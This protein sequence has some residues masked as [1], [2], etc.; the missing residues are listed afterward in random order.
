MVTVDLDW[1]DN[2]YTYAFL[3]GSDT[4]TV[5]VLGRTFKVPINT[6]DGSHSF[7]FDWQPTMNTTVSATA[8]FRYAPMCSDNVSP[9]SFGPCTFDLALRKTIVTP[10]SP[11]YK[12]G[13]VLQYR[14][15]VFNQGTIP[16]ANINIID[17]KPVGLE[18]V[19]AQNPDWFLNPQNNAEAFIPGPILPG[20]SVFKDI[21]Y[22]ILMHT[23]S[24]DAWTNFAEITY[25]ED[26]AGNNRSNYDVDSSPDK[27]PSNDAGGQPGTA[28]DNRLDGN[29]TDDS[30]DHDGARFSIFDL[31][32]IK[33]I[34]TPPPYTFGQDVQFDITVINQGNETANTI[35][36]VDNIPSG[37]S[38]RPVNSPAWSHSS[39]VATRTIVNP[40]LPGTSTTIP[41]I[42]RIESAASNQYVNIA[43]ISAATNSAGM[44]ATDFD[45]IFDSDPANDPGGMPDTPSDNAQ[46]G[47]GTGTG[48]PEAGD[49][50]NMDVARVAIPVISLQKS[51]VSIAPASSGNVANNDV[52]FSLTL[53]N[54]GNETLTMLTL[55]DNFIAQ[56]GGSFIRIVNMPSIF[57]STAT[58]NPVLN[59]AFNGGVNHQIFNGMTGVL[60]PTQSIQVRLTLELMD[61]DPVNPLVNEAITTGKD[62]F[63]S[64]V[65][66]TAQANVSLPTC[67]LKVNCPVPNQ[68]NFSCLSQVPAPATTVAAFNSQFG[69]NAIERFCSTP[70]ITASDIVTGTGCAA[71]PRVIMRRYIITDSGITPI[72]IQRD[73]C[74]VIYT[75][76]DSIKPV[77]MTP[78][79][80]II[81]ECGASG[82]TAAINTWLTQNGKSVVMDNCGGS[83]TIMNS[84]EEVNNTCGGTTN[85]KYRFT[86]TDACG[87]IQVAYGNVI[88][89]DRTA[90]SLTLPTTAKTVSCSPTT[91]ANTALANW[92][93][94]ASSSDACEGTI[95]VSHAL[96]TTQRVCTATNGTNV[97]N[98]YNFSATDSCGNFRTARDTFTIVDN[99]PPT[100]T[101]PTNLTVGCGQD[102]GAAVV[103][104][105]DNY[106]VSEACQTYSVTNNFNGQI[107][108]LCGGMQTVTWTVT[109]GCGATGST[110]AMI[111]VTNDNARPTWIN[112]PSDMTVNV[113]VD[114]C[115]A[116]VIFSRPIASDCNGP[117][118]YAQ[119]A[120]PISGS[121]FPLGSTL[122]R[123]TARDRCGNMDTCSFNIVVTDS[124][125]P[126]VR[127]PQ[128]IT[129]CNDPGTCTWASTV[130]TNPIGVDNCTGST[131]SYTISGVTSGSGNDSVPL[132]TSF[133]LGIS[134]I[135]YIITAP[136]G[137][138][139]T[140]RFTILVRDCQTPVITCPTAQPLF[141][142]GNATL[143]ADISSWLNT[144]SISDNCAPTPS[145]TVNRISTVDQCGNTERRL[146]QI[147]ATD[148]ANNQSSCFV[149]AV[150]TDT[151]R[152]VIVTPAS[153][154]TVQ[155]NGVGNI[156]SLMAWLTNHG[157]AVATDAGCGNE[158]RWSHNFNGL[159]DLCS[160][161][162]SA[163]VTFTVTDDCGNSRQTTATFTIEDTTPPTITVP[164]NLTLSCGNTNN[165]SIISGWL[166]SYVALDMCGSVTVTNDFTT[167]P[168]TCVAPNN[169]RVVTF[170][171]TDACG[172]TAQGMATVTMVDILKP[173]VM[174]PPSD[175]IVQCGQDNVSTISNWINTRGGAMIADE[176]APGL[177][178]TFTGAT[179]IRTCGSTA[180]TLYTL[181]ATDSCG[182]TVTTF[183]SLITIDTS[184]PIIT[185]P[186]VV[187]SVLCDPNTSAQQA[188]DTWLNNASASDLCQGNVNVVTSLI[189]T[190]RICRT[191]NQTD[192]LHI[193]LFTATDGC[194][195]ISTGRDTFRIYDNV[196]PN[197][198]A[199]ADLTI[200]CGQEIGAA[201]IP[202]LNGYTVTEACQT[203]T[204]TNNYDGQIPNLCGGSQA[205]MWT[206]T[207]GCGATNT[208]SANIVVA[209]NNNKPTFVNCPPNLTVNVDADLCSSNVIYSTPVAND[210]NGSVNVQRITGLASGSRFPL[211][212]TMIEFEAINACGVRDT[213]RF[214]ITV[215]DSIAP[216]IQCPGNDVVV[217]A[218]SS[219]V[220]L[221]TTAIN[222]SGIENCPGAN[223][224]YLITGQ[225]SGTGTGSVPLSTTF[226]LGTSTIRYI[227]IAA[228]GQRDTCQ[229]NVIVNDCTP[230]AIK[231]P[232]NL[233]LQCD[234]SGNDAAI[235]TWRN[236]VT[237]SDNCTV[238]I[239]FT[240]TL[241]S[242]VDQCGNSERRLY[243]FVA[244]D[245]ADNIASCFSEVIVR[246]TIKPAITTQASNLLVECDGQGNTAQL[247]N[248]L[249]TNGGAVGTD[250]CGNVRWTNNFG[251][252]S[253]LCGNSGA[254]TVRFTALDDCENDSTTTATFTIRDTS[255]PVLICPENITI[256]CGNTLNSAVISN[257]L[258][259]ATAQDICSG[260]V[261][262]T[263][264]YPGT[265]VAGCGNT[266]VH[267]VSF[268]ARDAC[269]SVTT[270]MRTITIIDT[271]RPIITSPPRDTV[272]QCDGT[273]NL[274]QLNTWLRHQAG[275]LARDTCSVLSS[276]TWTTPVLIH[277][278]NNC[279]G[280]RVYTYRFVSADACGNE[281]LPSFAT[282][283]ILDDTIPMISVPAK[284]SIVQCDGAGNN[285]QL[286]GWLSAHGGAIASDICSGPVTWS[287]N[288][289]RLTQNCGRTG[290]QHYRFTVMDACGKTNYTEAN[291]II[292]DTTRPVIVNPAVNFQ[293]QCDGSNNASQ[294]LNWLNNNGFASALD[295]CNGVTW[296]ND[297]GTISSPCGTTGA[298]NVT[299]TATDICG[300]RNTTTAIFT[301]R[302]TIA[303]RWVIA[304]QN[305]RLT[306]DGTSNPNEG[307][308]SWLNTVG[309]GLATDSCSLV[310]YSN[311]FT[312]LSN[313]CSAN[314][315][316][317]TVTFYGRD[318]CGNVDSLR[319]T[320]VVEDI[321]PPSIQ[322]PAKDT[323]VNCNGSGNISQLNIWLQN[324]GGAIASDRCSGV[325]TW[326]YRRIDTILNCG[327]T[328]EIRYAFTATDSCNNTSV[329]TIAKFII[330]DTMPPMVIQLPRDTV[331]QCNGSGNTGVLATWLGDFGGFRVSDVCSGPVT[332]SRTLIN[333]TDLC[334]L[335][336]NGRYKFTATDRCGNSISA[337]AE[338]AI[339]D[340]IAPLITPGADSNIGDCAS[341]GAGNYP[342][343]DFWLTNHAGAKAAD[344]CGGVTWSNNYHPSN[345]VTQCGNARFVFV[346]FYATD[347]CGNVDSVRYRFGVGDVSPPV[348]T[349][350]PRP[351]IIVDAPEGWCSA[352]ANFSPMTATDNCSVVTVRQIDNTG[353]KSGSLFPVG[354]TILYF[355]AKDGCG[356]ADTCSLK[357]IVNDFHVPPVMTC[358]PS[359]TVNNDP[360]RCGAIVNGLKPTKVEDNCS[361]NV[362]VSYTIRDKDN[363]IISCGFNDA[364]GFMFPVGNNIVSY[365]AKDQPTL[366][367]TEVINDGVRNGVEITNFGPAAVN[368]ACL[369]VERL[370]TTPEIYTVEDTVLRVGGVYTHLF[371]NIPANSPSGYMIRFMDNMIDGVATNGYS[372]TAF[373]WT[374][375]L[376][377]GTAYRH[378]VCDTD[379]SQDFRTID[380]CNPHSF[381]LFNPGLPV[382]PDNGDT[383]SLQ[384]RPPSIAVCNVNVNVRDAEFPYC[385][386][387]DTITYSAPGL[388]ANITS[389]LCTA[390]AV[391]VPVSPNNI[392]TDIN[393]INLEGT[394]PNVGDLVFRLVSPAGKEVTLMSGVCPSA[395]N[396]DINF[397]DEASTSIS[398][399]ACTTPVG[400]NNTFR[401]SQL[402]RQ[403]FGERSDGT[404]LL[405]VFTT[406]TH[407]G[408]LTNWQLQIVRSATYT[409][410]DT[411]LS[412][413]TGRCGANFRWQ[414]P[415]LA[416][417]CGMGTIRVDYTTSDGINVPGS[418]LLAGLGGQVTS[419]YFEVGTT[420]ITY[421]LTDQA[422]NV[423]RCSFE[424]TVQ[425]SERPEINPSSCQNLT[426]AL[427]PTQCE[428]SIPYPVLTANDNCGITRFVYSP[429]AGTRFKEGTHSVMLIVY[430]KAG[431]AD[432]CNFTVTVLPFVPS[433]NSMTCHSNINV[434]LDGNCQSV[435]GPEILLTGTSY[436]CLADYCVT[437][438]DASGKVIGS[439][440]NLTNIL[441]KDHI[442]KII[443]AKVCQDC[444]GNG[445]CCWATIKVEAK[446]IPV[447]ECPKNI[448]I[449]CNESDDPLFTG[450]PILKSCEPNIQISFVDDYDENDYC[451]NP[452]AVIDRI[453]TIRD[454][455]NNEVTCNQ[456][457][458]VLPF[459]LD[460]IRFPVDYVLDDSYDC[461]DVAKN[462]DLISVD[463]TGYPTISGKDVFGDHLCEFNIG[464]WD[465]KLIDA[466]C[467]SSFEILRHWIIRDECRPVEL[468]KNPLRHIQFIKVNDKKPPVFKRC[469]DD[470]TISTSDKNCTGEF[471]LPALSGLI[472]DG[473][474]SIRSISVTV[475]GGTVV[476]TGTG[477][478]KNYA[479]TNL[480][481][482]EHTVKI[483]AMDQCRNSALCIFK[484]TVLDKTPPLAICNG[485][486]RVSLS[487]DGK[488]RLVPSVLDRGSY[489][490][491]TSIGYQIYRRN[492][493]CAG[494]KDTLP[495]QHID[496]CCDD[497][498]LSPV[499]VVLRVWDDAD[500]DG[501]F[502]SPGDNY[503][504]CMSSVIV[505]YKLAP[506]FK[507]PDPVTLT[508][509]RDYK[510]LGLTGQPKVSQACN[511]A[512]LKFEDDIRALN[513]CGIGHVTRRWYEADRPQNSCQQQIIMT[514]IS[515]IDET[516]I[517]WP[518]D[519]TLF[520]TQTDYNSVPFIP[521]R[522]CHQ[523]GVT[524]KVDTIG[525]TQ[526]GCYKVLKHWTV[527]DWCQRE[528][529]PNKGKWTHTQT[530][531][532]TDNKAPVIQACQNVEITHSGC[533]LDTLDIVASAVDSGCV[534]NH[535][536]TWNVE[537][538]INDD[539]TID[540]TVTL[541][542][543]QVKYKLINANIGRLMVKWTVRDACNN[544][545]TCNQLIN[546]VSK[547]APLTYCKN[548][549]ISLS[550]TQDGIVLKAKDFNNGSTDACGKANFLNFSFSNVIADSVKRFN[551]SDIPNGVS[552]LIPITLWVSDKEGNKSQCAANL[553]V[554]DN[555]NQCPDLS[556]VTNSISGRVHTESGNGME[557][558]KLYSSMERSEL[559]HTVTYTDQSGKF[560][561]LNNHEG[562]VYK[563]QPEY[564]K[565]WLNGV[566]TLDLILIQRHILGL[567]QIKNPYLLLA[568]DVNNDSK[569]TSADLVVLRKLILGIQETV[570][571]QSSWIFV[572]KNF[573]FT[574]INNPWLF[575]NHL[576]IEQSKQDVVNADFIALKTGDINSSASANSNNFITEARSQLPFILYYDIQPL[577]VGGQ[578]LIRFYSSDIQYLKGLQLGFDVGDKGKLN[579][580]DGSMIVDDSEYHITGNKV[581][582]SLS[583]IKIND[584]S[585]K[586]LFG[587]I[588]DDANRIELLSN[589]WKNEAYL[590]DDLHI[591]PIKLQKTLLPNDENAFIV[592]QN[593]PNP[594]KDQTVIGFNI[595]SDDKVDLEIRDVNG[596]IVYQ[597]STYF[598]KGY[599]EWILKKSSLPSGVFSYT[600]KYKNESK[601]NKMIII[602]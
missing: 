420:V 89:L 597:N 581:R 40:L 15:E 218:N 149:E 374:G 511:L 159:S 273:G 13:D 501:V 187:D 445:N 388:P 541:H 105:L 249:N 400:Q 102:I 447:V 183:A 243:Y 371:T 440:A 36:V 14:I 389:G 37:Y 525:S 321:T 49:E 351:P 242:T 86:A 302:D 368:I 198:V 593:I 280:T 551:C 502:G 535:N 283:S 85:T 52:T 352:F 101:A 335:T 383:T 104:W 255:R 322:S 530:I 443:T 563:I 361:N 11:A 565:N 33:T 125:K 194:G 235:L 564:D 344:V 385:S 72:G 601:S 314:T 547:K 516:S 259:T 185:L 288:L 354:T 333:E 69:V 145:R 367:I 482:G 480:T 82:N 380:G 424:V 127:C 549:A 173:V 95:R 117:V 580:I 572:P 29:G 237:G 390:S 67:F 58:T 150:I 449:N 35:T 97:L 509:D 257:W 203:Y 392:I 473:C 26:N 83:V 171:A 568:A 434:S 432:T 533:S 468:N 118:T 452:R 365:T 596:K 381:G 164:S 318:A 384:S 500:K 300:N 217:C 536:L 319:A 496:L 600:L 182:N 202:W 499:M 460:S 4:I 236:S 462:P 438:M 60:A 338:F 137:Q 477:V 483:R 538:D 510:N 315:G 270:C 22:R 518:L 461:D 316:N 377:A 573:R 244:R 465:E 94:S 76:V 416:D 296:T 399:V 68:G 561:F 41:I 540:R 503:A 213:C 514:P 128:N 362:T 348:F 148:A 253:D 121:V 345:W 495:S 190:Q 234:D 93:N 168:N 508:C 116:N 209:L 413:E 355:E 195:I 212:T 251:T 179:P 369:S 181:T 341:T 247:L 427:N 557:D 34:V 107:P 330:R 435:I 405:E 122:V 458:V 436:G 360:L 320:V 163:V 292:Q 429:P 219:C 189:N 599:N 299:F 294:I 372:P 114:L 494:S 91:A 196:R 197:I 238:N 64:I 582:L 513:S 415:R 140:C 546:V 419:Q 379:N 395:A 489:D 132:N 151:I 403:F 486:L 456:K 504:E 241:I 139:D 303:P 517:K 560:S 425:D 350:C 298:V 223:I 524:V 167:L 120:G 248:W 412:N 261:T 263:N 529:D 487:S 23:G 75:V 170:T 155:C 123:F 282:F 143:E 271:Q 590:F 18:F 186:T 526:D 422:G 373:S 88:L 153:N 80:D 162:G 31:A 470:V 233:T 592:F 272:T 589:M 227:V 7:T 208:A 160:S 522:L 475:N 3:N 172:R 284:D 446:N 147:T 177:T 92:L 245:T 224:E 577:E 569:V 71:S 337:E 309:G 467:K 32:L 554:Q 210:C 323:I 281:S 454:I 325:R 585:G 375:T 115:S 328:R 166:E 602:E 230:P 520:C 100:I 542:G 490:N 2:V 534:L 269:D 409:Q 228:N 567:D 595:Y 537:I 220:W 48:S 188:L 39:G 130:A 254:V 43:E 539:G 215:Q 523:L 548:L 311:N 329:E 358:P 204:I 408:Q 110:S 66:D 493:S 453:W 552:V 124:Q 98:V 134:T 225:T 55:S 378:R 57:S 544:A 291:F 297:Y 12:Y 340:T 301:I 239:Q 53:Q 25:A 206:V 497:I 65:R 498:A 250:R 24:T 598:N 579:F 578:S 158:I 146:Y 221:S 588:A 491:C 51:V 144:A 178:Y 423:S 174:R 265:F 268:T 6:V 442:G 310:T 357:V 96:V 156:D 398:A 586:P 214:S 426:A 466:N 205:V 414:H 176:C 17:Y 1:E 138:R 591:A 543:N 382:M 262:L 441:N 515:S 528:L 587:F 339:I 550:N 119:I 267:T 583:N 77:F 289:V 553:S 129:V 28:N 81:L 278:L 38:Y 558:V 54:P 108:N 428:I 131:I 353:Y 46:N 285:A 401:P 317:A 574:D 410:E 406:G 532:F 78:P 387:S 324:N 566:S 411:V 73:T 331:V 222:P 307:I 492:T 469:F 286:S 256:E 59:T 246:D 308:T 519:T 332:Y 484:I 8:S 376:S 431:N 474:G 507:C 304:P 347:I 450:A 506:E 437:L 313:G 161:T 19:L 260:T 439:S 527:L 287:Y 455:D 16:A 199:P 111:I 9:G 472:E 364:S 576:M 448:T 396:F 594:W 570:P 479:F 463:S 476:S 10:T 47:N 106:S 391:S 5:D 312:R 481:V 157:G 112:C 556:G 306:C 226:N 216:R 193:Y 45:G 87:N 152:P 471:K 275:A 531:K 184:A 84:I 562:Q 555:A 180:N 74:T 142:C 444:S 211:G 295:A 327:L 485:N 113:D 61:V 334:G 154:R 70:T 133:G 44:S 571:N 418:G 402:L 575:P 136:N 30:D 366:L 512:Q 192:I 258:A 326:N 430:D 264:N 56:F 21:Y 200:S 349:N 545:S 240:S 505:D 417:N 79:C 109:D 207:D 394:Y 464:Y 451:G 342:E 363:T 50:D 488:A 305:L 404:W 90:P 457:I 135:Q 346:K 393:I 169:Q 126:S 343:F 359:V 232:S 277:T 276:L 386:T 42:L 274:S 20:Q 191:N 459:S 521:D 99:T 584:N 229:F 407:S 266:G 397:D 62:R 559:P 356:N 478:F 433:T 103:D 201:L 63:D 279:G 370:G 27:N 141:L 175:L 421:T 231:C 252:F 293:V 165:N 336:G 290:T